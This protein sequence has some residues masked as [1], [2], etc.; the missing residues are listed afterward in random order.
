M[1]YKYNHNLFSK[2]PQLH[3]ISDSR[4]DKG[5][6]HTQ[7]LSHTYTL[8]LNNKIFVPLSFTNFAPKHLFKTYLR[9][10]QILL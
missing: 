9:N 5:K 10:T 3:H 2:F 8:L 6:C 4:H 1:K 7:T